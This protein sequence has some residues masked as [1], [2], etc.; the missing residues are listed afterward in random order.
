MSCPLCGVRRSKRACPAIGQNICPVC[1]G[2]K[3]LTEIACPD[4]CI[5]LERAKSHPAAVVKRQQDRDLQALVGALGRVSESQLH[6]FFLLHAAIARFKPEGLGALAD[7]DVGDAAEALARTLET[8]SRGVLYEHPARS[9]I[10]EALR[11]EL[12]TLLTQVGRGGG[13]RFERAAIEV[14][15]GIERGA[16][17]DSQ[18]IGPGPRDYLSLVT[19]VLREQPPNVAERS[20]LVLP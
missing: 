14:L 4:D 19:R 3:R 11:R 5:F 20:S 7:A 18:G 16:K 1:C 9:P 10:A 2:T 6:L 12:N 8:S 15:R 17:H 13:T